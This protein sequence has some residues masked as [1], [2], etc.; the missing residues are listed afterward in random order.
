MF[1]EEFAKEAE[2]QI[3]LKTKIG[4]ISK[5]RDKDITPHVDVNYIDINL[6]LNA[7]IMVI[8]ICFSLCRLF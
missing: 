2:K 8:D 3:K 7:F 1:M 4:K 6:N 5:L